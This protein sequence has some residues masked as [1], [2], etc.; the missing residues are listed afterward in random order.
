MLPRRHMGQNLI[1]DVD[2]GGTS[3]P[4]RTVFTYYT[5]PPTDYAMLTRNPRCP[6]PSSY[7]MLRGS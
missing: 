7:K 6:H 2:Q 1:R 5:G 4:G 3:T